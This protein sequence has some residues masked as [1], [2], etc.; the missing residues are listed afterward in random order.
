MAN[1]NSKPNSVPAG[2]KKPLYQDAVRDT[3]VF[4]SATRDA[5]LHVYL[6][7]VAFYHSDGSLSDF[8]GEDQLQQNM[9]FCMEGLVANTQVL[10]NAGVDPDAIRRGFSVRVLKFLQVSINYYRSAGDISIT[11][12]VNNVTFYCVNPHPKY[13]RYWQ[14]IVYGA[15]FYDFMRHELLVKK[16]TDSLRAL[17]LEYK[18]LN[19]LVGKPESL[20]RNEAT[21]ILFCII[22]EWGDWEGTVLYKELREKYMP[23]HSR[24]YKVLNDSQQIG[25]HKAL[26][27]A[28]RIKSSKSPI[29]LIQIKCMDTIE[30]SIEP[31]R[32]VTRHKAAKVITGQQNAAT[33][34][35]SSQQ[36]SSALSPSAQSTSSKIPAQNPQQNHSPNLLP[37]SPSVP[38]REQPSTAQQQKPKTADPRLAVTP[39][40]AKKPTPAAQ[41]FEPVPVAAKPAA[42]P[43]QPVVS[44][45]QKHAR[46]DEKTLKAHQTATAPMKRQRM[47]AP[48][49][50][51]RESQAE[52]KAEVKSLSPV[53]I[54]RE[55]ST[56]EVPSTKLPERSAEKF[57]EIVLAEHNLAQAG[58]H[59]DVKELAK[60]VMP[61]ALKLASAY[62]ATRPIPGLTPE[63]VS[64]LANLRPIDSQSPIRHETVP[65]VMPNGNSTVWYCAVHGCKYFLLNATSLAGKVKIR[66]HYAEH[67]ADYEMFN[68]EADDVKQFGKVNT[69]DEEKLK[70]ALERKALAKKSKKH[71]QSGADNRNVDAL[72]SKLES[73]ANEWK[74]F[75]DNL[76]FL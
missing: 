46:D 12:Y 32:P 7:D 15:K 69:E 38:M 58:P 9:Y 49:E 47:A 33:A 73:I 36:A 61:N 59:H 54:K 14:F 19:P 57:K 6:K 4:A 5:P 20:L 71:K 11:V 62:R 2:D 65:Q 63:L 52:I 10:Q 70:L 50:V 64:T 40:P 74:R 56:T 39:P 35:T 76:D 8:T 72:V 17:L 34:Q 67:V 37:A 29:V 26:H 55:T 18:S 51:Q 22:R 45:G 60:A 53:V 28:E 41:A 30:N 68:D 3:E 23:L 21:F 24:I 66:D 25:I 1:R 13:T 43:L 42:R 16:S 31:Y 44:I 27:S 48:T 75:D